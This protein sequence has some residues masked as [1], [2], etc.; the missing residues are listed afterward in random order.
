MPHADPEEHKA[1]RRRYMKQY[2]SDPKNRRR[3]IARV[4]A[5]GK[6][7]GEE[8]R[9]ILA[10]FK[11]AGCALCPEKA[12]CCLSAHHLEGKDFAVSVATTGKR[13]SPGRVVAELKKCVCLCEN[14]HRKVHAGILEIVAGWSSPVSSQGS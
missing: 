10:S 1:Y 12:P 13:F 5:N 9:S 7:Y 14:C 6:R 11:S 8:I 4:R 2:L 3:H